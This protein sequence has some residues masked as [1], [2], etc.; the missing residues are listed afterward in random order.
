MFPRPNPYSSILSLTSSVHR[1]GTRTLS[2]GLFR[3]K[4]KA[5][6]ADPSSNKSTVPSIHDTG[7]SGAFYPSLKL[8]SA[9]SARPKREKRRLPLFP[10][11]GEWTGILGDTAGDDAWV[12]GKYYLGNFRFLLPS[13]GAGEVTIGI[14]DGVGA[15]NTKEKGRPGLWSRLLMHYWAL[16]CEERMKLWKVDRATGRSRA[17]A[18]VGVDFVSTEEDVDVVQMLHQAYLRTAIEMEQ[19]GGW[20]GSTTACV[21][22]LQRST[23]HIANVF[24]SLKVELMGL[25]RRFQGICYTGEPVHIYDCGTTTLV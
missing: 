22:L 5:P 14:A 12:V 15:W 9:V 18:G 24:S 20:V 13:N 23:L 2:L 6:V 8:H 4:K 1:F 10:E 21:A 3:E 16:E 11:G 19:S 25:A 7:T 17:A